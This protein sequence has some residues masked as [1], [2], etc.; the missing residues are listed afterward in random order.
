MKLK[1]KHVKIPST[2]G[3]LCNLLLPRVISDAH[4]YEETTAVA[5]RLALLGDKMNRD[6]A[7]YY[8]LLCDV[9]ERYEHAKTPKVK[10]LE[11][12]AHLCEENNMSGAQLA[13]VLHVDRS[14][15]PKILS[16]ERSITAKHAV[17][18][19]KRFGLSPV[20]FLGN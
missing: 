7:D 10:P 8:E 1:P 17:L 5:E 2:Y 18:L 9:I 14:M 16:G 20:A 11:V 15:G 3:E 19:G 4:D 6:Q 12:L 13:E